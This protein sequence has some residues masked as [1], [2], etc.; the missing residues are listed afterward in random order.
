MFVEAV[1]VSVFFLAVGLFVFVYADKIISFFLEVKHDY[2]RLL[3]GDDVEPPGSP[4][5]GR[6]TALVWAR[7]VAT[8]FIVF[9]LV[10]L[11]FIFFIAPDLETVVSLFE[12]LSPMI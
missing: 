9:S 3:K 11:W 1:L 12:P 5:F 2:S 4:I 7:I 6:K 10:L 8:I